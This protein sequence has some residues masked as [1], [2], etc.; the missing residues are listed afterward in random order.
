M[1]H[2]ARPVLLTA[3]HVPHP[4]LAILPTRSIPAVSLWF[5]LKAKHTWPIATLAAFLAWAQ[6][7]CFALPVLL[8]STWVQLRAFA[9]LVISTATA[10]SVQ[11][12]IFHCVLPAIL[13]V[14]LT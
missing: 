12:P 5:K 7:P 9:F 6:I 1:A 8:G 10:C 4:P 14:S 3:P 2:N 11:L 13:E